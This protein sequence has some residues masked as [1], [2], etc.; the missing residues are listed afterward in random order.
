MHVELQKRWQKKGK[1]QNKWNT[2]TSDIYIFLFYLEHESL[3]LKVEDY[4]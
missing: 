3:H 2:L 1:K 4:W